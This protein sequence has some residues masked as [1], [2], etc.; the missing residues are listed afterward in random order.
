M[1]VV[2]DDTLW[3]QYLVHQLCFRAPSLLSL[4]QRQLY[5][6]TAQPF[7]VPVSPLIS[8]RPIKEDNSRL[9]THPLWITIVGHLVQWEIFTTRFGE[10]FCFPVLS[11]WSKK[12]C[13]TQISILETYH[14][15]FTSKVYYRSKKI[16]VILDTGL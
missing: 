15:K 11:L 4:K 10:N 1:R 14:S 7:E 13:G 12:G 6:I 9:T 5:T 16:R 8:M 2:G 3:Q